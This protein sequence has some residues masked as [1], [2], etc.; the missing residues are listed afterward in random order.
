[1]T[2]SHAIELIDVRVWKNRR[3]ILD[4]PSLKLPTHETFSVIGPNG[5]GKTTL[6]RIISLLDRPGEGQVLHAGQ[7]ISSGRETLRRRRRLAMVMQQPALRNSSVWENVLTG[8]RF[9]HT[10]K[11]IASRKVGEWLE[12]LG[13][14]HL[15]DRNARRLSGGEAQRVNMARG[16]VLEPDLLLLDE[17]FNGLDQPT[18]LALMDDL[19]RILQEIRTSTV[20]VT[21]DRGEAQALSSSVAVMLDGKVEQIGDP[22]QVFTAPRTEEIASFVGVENVLAAKVIESNNGLT[23]ASVGEGLV[24]LAGEYPTGE[25]LV[26][27]ISPEAVVIEDPSDLGATTSVRNRIPGSV[28]RLF[29]MGAQAR[30]VV[31]CGFPLVSLVPG[32]SVV[33]LRLSPGAQVVASFKASAVHVIRSGR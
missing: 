18:R 21:H 22:D 24:S 29:E 32:S 4:V 26:L 8:H 3:L 25:D 33:D 28:S 13:I 14:S 30:V 2:E 15:S 5:A 19:W 6:L 20:L 7:R 16:L 10:P 23:T 27:G 12:R 17:P 9:R 31:E 11:D 1:M